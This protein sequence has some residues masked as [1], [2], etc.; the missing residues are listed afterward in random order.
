M[1]AFCIRLVGA[2]ELYVE[3]YDEGLT[4]QALKAETATRE[5]SANS[6]PLEKWVYNIFIG[7][8]S[9]P[10]NNFSE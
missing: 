5:R 8:R 10:L 9:F 7:M 6:H 2:V 4:A 3:A 1:E